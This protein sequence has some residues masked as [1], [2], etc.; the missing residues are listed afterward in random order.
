[1]TAPQT[2]ILTGDTPTG[3][4]HIGHWVGSV[5]R[6]V[7]LQDKHECFFLIANLHAFTTRADDPAAIRSD[8]I[9]IARDSMAMGVDPAKAAIF[10]QTEV[11]A[12]LELTYL[13]AMLLP[14]NRVM[15]NPTLKD[16]LKVKDL[17][18][19]YSFGFPLY[20]VGQCADIL[21]FRAHAVPVGEDQVPH[22]ELTRE[23]AR[24]FNKMY[25]G[26]PD[27]APDEEHES[28]GGVFPIPV[29]DVGKV[30]RLIGTD[31]VNK[32]SKSLGNAI[33]ITDTPKKVKKKIG[34]I[35]TGQDSRD[36]NDPGEVDP[37]KNPLFQYLETFVTDESVIDDVRTR[38]AAGD[39]IGDGEVKMLVA[40]AINELLDPMRERRE[41]WASDDD[42]MDVLL[43]GSRKAN[44]LCEETLT[45]AK[46]AA[47]LRFFPRTIEL[48]G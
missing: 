45:M 18:D 10:L 30:G 9:E 2:R 23:V 17:K 11:P 46:D 21:T 38:Y 37:A 33:H 44:A 26:V 16:E 27:K 12:I 20:T 7:E 1:M 41:Q 48:G 3:N 19:N 14:Y 29:A 31:G 39:N 35:Y 34:R 42:V 15:R 13:F 6:R 36:P 22:L 25:C 43:E 8:C 28:L 4:L 32:M 47:K 40:D 5:Q 24:R